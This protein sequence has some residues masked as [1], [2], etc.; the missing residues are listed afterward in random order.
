MF[1]ATYRSRDISLEL[2][3]GNCR[4]FAQIEY[5][6]RC[7]MFASFG[8]TV[9]TDAPRVLDSRLVALGFMIIDWNVAL[10]C[11]RWTSPLIRMRTIS[12]N[13]ENVK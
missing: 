2:S 6:F 9:A 13:S 8:S 3:L 5:E 12:Y 11:I 10:C 4:V 7:S 1:V